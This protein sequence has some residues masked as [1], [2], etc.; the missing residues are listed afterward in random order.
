[1]TTEQV[2]YPYEFAVFPLRR[3][4]TEVEQFVSVEDYFHLTGPVEELVGWRLRPA[5]EPARSR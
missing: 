1:M 2:R 3:G 4:G 5:S